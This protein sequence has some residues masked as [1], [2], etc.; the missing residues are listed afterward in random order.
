MSTLFSHGESLR[1]AGEDYAV[2]QLSSS[3]QDSW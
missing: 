3:R 2:V 1:H